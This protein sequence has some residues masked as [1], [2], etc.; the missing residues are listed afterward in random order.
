M[1][2]AVA[3]PLGVAAAVAYGVAAA[4]QHDAV[5]QHEPGSTAP[6]F[7]A[8]LRDPRWLAASSGDVVGLVLQLAALATGPVVLIQP[9]FVLCL[10]VALPIRAMFGGTAPRRADYLAA[11]ALALGLAGF[12][13][14]AGT[15]HPSKELHTGAA[16]LI[17]V[18]AL[19]VGLAAVLCVRQGANAR[20]AVILSSVTGA[21]FGV[22]AVL[23]NSTATAFNRDSWAAFGTAAGLT[24]AL[25]ALIVGSSGFVLSQLAFQAGNLGASFPAMLVLDP[26]VAVLLGAAVLGETTRSGVLALLGYSLCLVVIVLATVR[27]ARPAHDGLTSRLP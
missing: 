22:E 8:L 5:G 16:L 14:I 9:L 27:L 1:N 18:I 2:L 13:A 4:F 17:A 10:P 26:L 21:W 19:G 24:A 25:G 11:L 23:V 3:I 12:F 6:P 20:R 7:S 15:P